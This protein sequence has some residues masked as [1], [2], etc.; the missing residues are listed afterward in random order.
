MSPSDQDTEIVPDRSEALEFEPVVRSRPKRRIGLVL[1]LLVLAG[2][3]AGAGWYLY[4][5]NLLAGT[6]GE[7]PVIRAADGPVKVRPENPGGMA[8]PDRDKLI[9]ERLKGAEEDYRVERLLPRP[10]APLAPP[11]P[12]AETVKS[13]EPAIAEK[14]VAEPIL[15]PASI[16]KMETVA[17]TASPPPA[18]PPVPAANAVPAGPRN[19]YRVQLAAV[20]SEDAAGSEWIRLKKKNGDLLDGLTL[21]VIRVD[22]GA[23]KGVFYRL[24]AGP[25]ASEAAAKKLCERLSSRKIGCLIVRPSGG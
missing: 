3:S 6:E 17:K 20:R 16:P 12:T 25:L 5:G 4:G 7:V 24:R 14:P 9:Y 1:T 18:P 2:G 21:N 11:A 23:G 15:N 13:P 8:I 19:V 22:L 10:E